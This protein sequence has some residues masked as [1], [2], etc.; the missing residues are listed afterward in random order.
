M[1]FCAC[2]CSQLHSEEH[3]NVEDTISWSRNIPADV[4]NKIATKLVPVES[5]TMWIDP[6]DA[7]QEYTGAHVVFQCL[8][9]ETLDSQRLLGIQCLCACC[10]RR[11]TQQD[12]CFTQG[13]IM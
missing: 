5:V 12:G 11:C 1:C 13:M 6:L 9:K 7:T 2:V 3:D 8:P 10:G 4:L